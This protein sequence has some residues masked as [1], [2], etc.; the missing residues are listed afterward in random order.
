MSTKPGPFNLG[1]TIQQA[2]ALH[3]Q[4]R[5]DE[6]EKLY[7]RVLKA[8]R[9]NFDALHLLG[10]L[11]HQRG[12]AGEAYRLINAALKVQPRSPDALSNLALVLHALK[13]SAEAL[14]SLD[15]ALALAPGHLDALNNRGNRAARSQAAMPRRSLLSMRC[16]RRR[17]A[18]FQALIN[19][20]NARAA[21]RARLEQALAEYDAA[22]AIAPGHPLALYNRGNALRALGRDS[23]AIAAYDG[24]LSAAPNYPSAWTNRGMA[25]AALNRHQD[26]L[27]SY[28]RALA[29]AAGQRRCAFQRGAGAADGRRLCARALRNTSGAGSAP[30]WRARKDLGKP[31]WLGETP[32]AGK[33]ILLHAE[34]GLGRHDHVRPLCAA[35]G[36]RGARCVLEVQPELKDLLAGLE[37]VARSSRAASRCRRSTCI[38]R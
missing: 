24:A 32:L 13:R 7:T 15:K 27:A 36:A 20:G 8:Q 38:A 34:Q 30:A 6:A 17:R 5:L 11:N 35:A 25:L 37:G 33:T 12:K 21:A 18:I 9:D 14:A 28:G 23:D 26:A 2:L 31:L 3:Q 16:W 4:G 22:L 10:M 1:E 29:L 19:R